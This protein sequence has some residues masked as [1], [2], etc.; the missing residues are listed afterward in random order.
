MDAN[1]D[2]WITSS[3]ECFEINLTRP[4]KN[5]DEPAPVF[6]EPFR[7][8]FTYPIFEEKEVLLGYK[9]PRIDLT[10]RA[11][12]LKPSLKV[13][14]EAKVD[15]SSVLPDDEKQIDLEK[16]W[17]D[18]LPASTTIS[19]D[20][21]DDPTAKSWKPP[22][23]LLHSFTLLG[24]QY[25]IWSANLTDPLALAIWENM[26]ILTLLFIE[27]ASYPELDAQW[28][29][30]RWTLYLLYEV[31]PI[32][33][34]TSPYTLAGFS[35]SYRYWIFPTYKIMRATNSLPTPPS[36]TDGHDAS[37][38]TGPRLT[39]DPQT[40]L[41]TNQIS[42]LESPSR[43]RISQFMILPPYQGQ[44]L[45]SRLYDTI[46]EELVGKPFIYEIP[47]EDPSEDFDAMRDYSDIVYLRAI[48]EFA[49]LT[50]PSTMPPDTMRKSAPIPREQ[51]LGNG[52]PTTMTIDDLRLKT[53]IVDRQFNRMLELHLLSAIPAFNRNKARITRKDKSSSENDRKYYFWRLALKNRIYRQNADVLDQLEDQ[54]EKVER[55]EMAVDGQQ[56]E[57]EEREEGMER[58][59]K[60]SKGEIK[61]EEAGK[62]R[63]KRKRTVVDDDE[64]DEWEEIDEEVESSSSKRPKV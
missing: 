2:E 60:W 25:E 58:R 42:A 4:T 62:S 61:S 64:D 19:S 37:S 27:G 43:E 30:E 34:D 16:V 21:S 48:P 28:T 46:F 15:L 44:S 8:S 39:V 26:K 33:E 51:I 24:K 45:G 32:E 49:A 6:I 9:D 5:E 20:R 41:F 12:D 55:L 14:F 63:G 3:N 40:H 11:N 54:G 7:P 53:K 59:K 17:E 47:V 31:T 10:F 23:R 1:L 13:A 29:L 50:L 52:L 57:Y 38:Y 36:S 56:Q 35:T 18:F 22:G